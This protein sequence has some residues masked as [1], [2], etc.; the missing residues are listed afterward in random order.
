MSLT[1]ETNIE[2]DTTELASG[3]AEEAMRSSGEL[4]RVLKRSTPTKAVLRV[5][6]AKDG[7]TFNIPT[8]S[9]P[10]IAQLLEE[11]AKGNAVSVSSTE[12]EVS[13][14][15]AADYLNVSRPFLIRLLDEGR[16]PHRKVGNRRRVLR[17]DL[18]TYKQIS[19]TRRRIAA[20]LLTKEAQELGLYD[21]A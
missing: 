9:L 21:D 8:S 1:T 16:I 14:Q 10:I 7:A 17:S 11:L 5:E 6:S 18:E 13:T 19:D 15:I 2:I 3:D 20:D 12:E 4:G